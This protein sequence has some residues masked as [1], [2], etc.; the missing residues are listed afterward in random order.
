MKGEPMNDL[1]L[2]QLI[3][4][5]QQRDA[6]HIAVVPVVATEILRP[7]QDIRLVQG[8][9]EWVEGAEDGIGIVDP[10]LKA[11]V[12]E[13]QRFWMFLYPGTITSL[14]H[15]W[16]HPAFADKN[17]S[18]VWLSNFIARSD[19]PSYYEVLGAAINHGTH[20]GS[21]DDEYLHFNEVDAHGNIPPEFWDHV[22]VV[23]G[24]KMEHRAK[25]FSCSC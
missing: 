11:A 10:F 22:E 25:S 5:P 2:G 21:F 14:R 23:S 19:C 20:G 24:Q 12:D 15:D 13:G 6:I 8:S 4:T 18:E 17:A 7:G 1:K 16:T 9:F 3:T